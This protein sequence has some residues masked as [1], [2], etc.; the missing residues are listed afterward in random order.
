MCK[1][2]ADHCCAY[3]VS[4]P[5]FVCSLVCE[6]MVGD[7]CYPMGGAV[8]LYFSVNEENGWYP[9]VITSGE[10]CAVIKLSSGDSLTDGLQC[11]ND[12]VCKELWVPDSVIIYIITTCV[13]DH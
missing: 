5:Y 9:V 2:I 4:G 13:D 11:G 12:C 8:P 6:L 10:Y 7:E 1:V 3:L